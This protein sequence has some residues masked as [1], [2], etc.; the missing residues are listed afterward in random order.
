MLVP[1]GAPCAHVVSYF[2]RGSAA[3]LGGA[4]PAQASFD[5]S[6]SDAPRIRLARAEWGLLPGAVPTRPVLV[7]PSLLSADFARLAD[8][9]AALEEAGAD[10]V[11]I[12]VMDG[13]FVPNLTLGPPVVR[14]LR[15]VTKLPLDVHLMVVEPERLIDAF[16]DAGADTVTVHAE[17][18]VHLHRTLEQ[19]R[20]RGARAGVS[21]N[22]HTSEEAVRYLRDLVGLVL[23]MSVN[24]GFGGQRFLPLVLPKL[25][26][27]RAMLPS[28]VL[29]E[30]DGGVTSANAQALANAGADVLVAGS[31]VFGDGTALGQGRAAA[32]YRAAMEALRTA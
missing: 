16:V 14:A 11:H 19:V 31:S 15:K 20:T 8:E 6:P 1:E 27:L 2:P 22:P 10:W 13:R 21:L 32:A 5:P 29:L 4:R 9:L 26:A 18:C 28:E 25:Q 30:V 12:D 7:A 17:A 24:P 23:V 3:S